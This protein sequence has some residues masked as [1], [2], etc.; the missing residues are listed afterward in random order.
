MNE[1]IYNKVL[2]LASL[3]LDYGMI[4]RK[5]CHQ[6]GKTL[7][8]DTTHTVMLG[9]IGNAISNKFYPDMDHGLVSQFALIHDFVEVYA[10]D[11]PTLHIT[12]D[13]FF[14]EKEEREKLAYEKI[15][16]EFHDIFPWISE[17]IDKYEKLDT[18]EARFIKTL[19]KILPKLTVVL[20]NGTSDILKTIKKTEA[21][22]TF[23][24]Q[25]VMVEEKAC[26]MNEIIDLWKYF[27]DKE[28]N[29]I[30]N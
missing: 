3:C 6:D 1:K 18:K 4:F 15:K 2:E 16:N 23:D 10:G 11:T 8:S 24:R 22:K 30:K 21:Q 27:V 25:R 28:L 7:E 5:T 12:H 17:T 19:D 13:T 20:N 14:Q 26:D 29:L 9:V